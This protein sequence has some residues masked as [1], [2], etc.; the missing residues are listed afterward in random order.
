M[1]DEEAL[2]T[3]GS[4]LL[5]AWAWW[6]RRREGEQVD[7]YGWCG[8]HL[9][10]KLDYEEEGRGHGYRCEWGRGMGDGLKFF[11]MFH[12]KLAWVLS[13]NYLPLIFLTGENVE[14]TFICSFIFY[15]LPKFKGSSTE[16]DDKEIEPKIY[17]VGY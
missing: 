10:K 2:V 1:E 8:I 6:E 7:T 3:T 17:L 9:L 11:I 16:F 12:L 14:T 5:L 15:L 13:P 4:A